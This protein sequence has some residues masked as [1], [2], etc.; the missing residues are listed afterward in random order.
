MKKVVV[1]SALAGAAIMIGSSI[2]LACPMEY[3]E[4]AVVWEEN[5]NGNG[6][7]YDIIQLEYCSDTGCLTWEDAQDYVADNY[8]DEWYL[9]TITSAEENT[10]ITSTFGAYTHGAW[11]GGYQADNDD[12][13]E[14]SWAW[15]TGEEFD[16][17][18]WNIGEPNDYDGREDFLELYSNGLWN[19][20]YNDGYLCEIIIEKGSYQTP[21]GQNGS[22]VPEPTTM[23]LFGT[24]IAGL[25]A[26]SRRKRN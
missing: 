3:T 19:D 10:F 24:G 20:Y 25:A 1:I 16:F 26:V 7:T 17:T 13:S 9:A 6:H 23:L 8:G 12:G 14:G 5:D 21:S 4:D 18:N 22:A 15:V 11:I 2:T